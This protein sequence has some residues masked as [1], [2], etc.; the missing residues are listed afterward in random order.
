M[1]Q[2]FGNNLLI[3]PVEQNTILKSAEGSMCEYGIVTAIGSEVKYLKVGDKIGFTVW[4]VNKLNIEDEKHYFI[5][6]D[7]RFILGILLP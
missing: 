5:S 6:E 4:G 7:P 2:P 1:I 3:K